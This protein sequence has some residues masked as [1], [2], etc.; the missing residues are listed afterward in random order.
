MT[1]QVHAEPQKREREDEQQSDVPGAEARERA[2]SVSTETDE[3]LDD[4]D[5]LL[6]EM[7]Q[8][9]AETFRQKNG[10]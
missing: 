7:P 6:N 4:I 3:L 9:L 2:A 1:A 5:A 10:Q 8:D